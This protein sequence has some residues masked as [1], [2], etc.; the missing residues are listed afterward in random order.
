MTDERTPEGGLTEEERRLVGYLR[1]TLPFGAAL[2]DLEAVKVQAK[3]EALREAADLLDATF[4]GDLFE[5]NAMGA[6]SEGEWT[7]FRWLATSTLRERA[8]R[9]AR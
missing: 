3:A 7:W 4:R 9:E 6:A 5:E 8:D 1:H 2:D